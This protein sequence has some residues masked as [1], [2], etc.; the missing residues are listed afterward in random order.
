MRCVCVCVCERERERERVCVCEKEGRM[1]WMSV[2]AGIMTWLCLEEKKN[3]LSALVF[4]LY[5]SR[6]PA[7]CVE[8]SQ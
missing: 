6:K 1:T 7:R 8:N 3:F 4:N 5:T 2:G